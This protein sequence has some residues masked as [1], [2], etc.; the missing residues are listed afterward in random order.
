MLGYLQFRF[1][2]QG[3]FLNEMSGKPSLFVWDLQVLPEVQRHGLGKHLLT[4]AELV[5]R[6]QKMYFLQVLCPEVSFRLWQLKDEQRSAVLFL[7]PHPVP[8][9][10]M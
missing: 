9:Y 6:Q 10:Q 7:C 2:F 3:E 1:S 4:V 5:A 8:G